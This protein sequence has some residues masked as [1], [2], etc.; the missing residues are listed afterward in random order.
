MPNWCE[1]RMWVFGFGEAAF[2]QA[3]E[4]L[5]KSKEEDSDLVFHKLVPLNEEDEKVWD[6]KRAVDLWG[7]KWDPCDVTLLAS[8]ERNYVQ[9]EYS[10]DTAWAPPFAWLKT[11]SKKFPDLLFLLTYFE[12]GV[13]FM[14]VAK[15]QAGD[16]VIREL[17]WG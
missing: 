1:N 6:Y 8:I 16:E 7:T 14:G 4:F 5:D 10:F 3:A 15:Y 17:T 2:E 9:L 12:P 11:V 13:G